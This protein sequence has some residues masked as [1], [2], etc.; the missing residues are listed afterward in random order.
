[1]MKGI[2]GQQNSYMTFIGVHEV[3]GTAVFVVSG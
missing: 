1:M 2:M 3:H